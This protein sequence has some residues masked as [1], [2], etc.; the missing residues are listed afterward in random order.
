MN[1]KTNVISLGI[2]N[3]ATGIGA[4]GVAVIVY[5]LK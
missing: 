1:G 3:I 5:T 2:K 4:G